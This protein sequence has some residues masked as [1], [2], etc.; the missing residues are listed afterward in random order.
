VKSDADA[1][2]KRAD[3]CRAVAN[4][5]KDKEAE[6]E[7]RV[8]AHALDDEAATMSAEDPTGCNEGL[9]AENGSPK[10]SSWQDGFDHILGAS[11]ARRTPKPDQQ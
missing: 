2:R 10:R 6:R 4:G 3:Q 8:L 11:F 5:T 7:L 9:S 1:F